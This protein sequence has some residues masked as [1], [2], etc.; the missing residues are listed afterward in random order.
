MSAADLRTEFFDFLEAWPGRAG[1]SG[2]SF[3]DLFTVGHGYSIWWTSVAAD[4]QA[5]RGLVKY[6][7]YA[8]LVDQLFAKWRPATIL[9]FTR[10]PLFAALVRIRAERAGVAIRSLEGSAE[11]PSDEPVVGRDWLWR[12][13]WR[14]V[15]APFERLRFSMRCARALRGA[16]L[17]RG[18]ARPTVLFAS[19]W[20]RHLALREGTFTRIY[21]E[22]IGRA[23]ETA[24]PPCELAYLPRKLQEVVDTG[25]TRSGLAALQGVRA[26]LVIWERYFPVRAVLSNVVQQISR[27]WRFY[28]LARRR[29]FRDSFRFAHTDLTAILLPEL[30]AGIERAIDW[31]CKSAQ[32]GAALRA[33]GN[34]R[35]VLVSEEMYQPAM[36]TLAAAKALGIPTIGVQHGTI[37][38]T[39]FMYALPRGH[40][41]HAPVPDFFCAYGEYGKEVLS[42]HGAYPSDR[43]WVTGAARLDPLVTQ[44]PDRAAARAALGLPSGTRI[45]VLATQTFPWFGSA[46]RGV[47]ECMRDHPE[48]LLCVKK[49]PS[50]H[51]MP[52]AQIDAMAEELGVRNVQTFEKHTELLL[53]ACSVWISASSTTLLE[54][55]LIGRPTICLNFS[56]QPDRY[57]YVDEGVSLPARSLEELRRSLTQVL[58]PAEYQVCETRRRAFLNRHL[59]PTTEGRAADTLAQRVAGFMAGSL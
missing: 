31:S 17:H 49:N 36:P 13:L 56:G 33:A 14:A 8:S 55:T 9:L 26:P 48:A 30:K 2:R 43:V 42:V 24:H 25:T 10:D 4:R 18:S 44:L 58:G 1:R 41:Q 40:V 51:A 46:M 27:V 37:M 21:W 3:N 50:I 39:H 12:S 5:T 34:V 35:A 59:G 47:L 28:R 54:A 19:T 16:K 11:P 52:V 57:P 22:E 38:P 32:V 20:P 45:V 15:G 7:R 53:S 23:I 6:F 29:E